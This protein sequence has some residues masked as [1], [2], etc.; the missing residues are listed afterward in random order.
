MG[1]FIYGNLL[2]G[3][4]FIVAVVEYFN[5]HKD[6]VEQKRR[7][8]IQIKYLF[9]TQILYISAFLFTP[10][11]IEGFLYPFKIFFVKDFANLKLLGFTISELGTP[12]M[13]YMF[14]LH[15]TWFYALLGLS[16]FALGRNKEMRF[17]NLLLFV[18]SVFLY[19]HGKRA[20]AFFSV[21]SGYVIV[22]G[23]KGFGKDEN[24]K[25][26]LCNKK[27]QALVYVVVS[28]MLI[29]QT[30]FIV[31]KRAFF[32][33]S[34][35]R[36]MFSEYAPGPN[37]V[38]AVEFLKENN[39][40]GLIFN[41]INTGGYISW[42][43]YP[44]LRPFLD[45][46]LDGHPLNQAMF[47]QRYFINKDTAGIWPIVDEQHNFKIVMY[48]LSRPVG[49]NF[50][51]YLMSLNT[52]QLVFFEGAHFVFVKK[53][54]FDLPDDIANYEVRLR[55]KTVSIEDI[56]RL[57]EIVSASRKESFFDFLSFPPIYVD[58]LEEAAV[59][60]D[61]GFRGEAVKRMLSVSEIADK[62]SIEQM[63][64][65]ILKVIDKELTD[66]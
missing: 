63:A 33:N 27:I 61:L 48:D 65:V 46:R 37:P 23:M 50:A 34:F 11:G 45:G 3:I 4:F 13:E 26:F 24:I 40:G 59:L 28:F 62:K 44:E 14:S 21:V 5:L 36:V 38:R 60:F 6:R 25:N 9:L 56:D 41:Q 55:E 35:K 2:I 58:V 18:F 52:W 12:T 39:I 7:K 30:Y 54:E 53:G 19:L 29:G 47:K 42:T 15:S 57:K 17:L 20:A 8:F 43:S 66:E 22:Q 64:S 1:S 10:Y 16:I 31:N 49:I 32:N 51:K